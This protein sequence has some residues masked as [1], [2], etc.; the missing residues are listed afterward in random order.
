MAS[1]KNNNSATNKKIAD[2]AKKAAKT[3]TKKAAK[4]AVN[5]SIK[6]AKKEIRQENRI[7]DRSVY[8]PKMYQRVL[9]YLSVLFAA[10][11]TA[12][13]ITVH[14]VGLD[15]G[16]GKVGFA[17]QALFCGIFGLGAFA[18]PLLFAYH[19]IRQC[20][21]HVK[22]QPVKLEGD[23]LVEFLKA[24]KKFRLIRIASWVLIV[25]LS[26]LIAVIADQSVYDFADFWVE[27]TELFGGG[28][29]GGSIG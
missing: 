18:L 11:L 17:I 14:L 1:T 4:K 21:F 26:S 2:A 22:W 3:Q 8:A 24:R 25:L 15:S 28:I 12:C 23:D 10:I 13:F 27:G 9:P 7:Q 6:D 29:I 5:K 16:A 19:G 20:I